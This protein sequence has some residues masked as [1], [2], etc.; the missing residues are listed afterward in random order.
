M[1]LQLPKRLLS[2][3]LVWVHVRRMAGI[4]ERERRCCQTP[5][6]ASAAT[7]F[8]ADASLD[9]AHTSFRGSMDDHNAAKQKALVDATVKQFTER[10][11]NENILRLNGHAEDKVVASGGGAHLSI[12]EAGLNVEE[13]KGFI[14]ARTDKPV[15]S[16]LSK[17]ELLQAEAER[18]REKPIA[19]RLG[20]E[21]DDYAEWKEEMER[22]KREK[23]RIIIASSERRF[24]SD[25]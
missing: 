8:R 7:Q 16:A 19:I 4:M 6:L 18:I 24:S 20:L 3:S 17:K 22:A 25:P 23:S 21:P 2:V 9:V 1:N 11:L 13:L 10:M 14:R 12:K 5:T 15:P